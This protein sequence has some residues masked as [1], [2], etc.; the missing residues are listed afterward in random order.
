M[1]HSQQRFKLGLI[2]FSIGTTWAIRICKEKTLSTLS[3]GSRF[4]P[5]A[6]GLHGQA[7]RYLVVPRHSTVGPRAFSVAGPS[8]WNSIRCVLKTHRTEALSV[9]EMFQDVTLYKLTYRYYKRFRTLRHV[10]LPVRGDAIISVQTVNSLQLPTVVSY[11]RRTLP[12]SL[13]HEPTL[14]S[15]IGHSRLLDHGC[16]TA[17]RPT[18][19]SPTLPYISSAAR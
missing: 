2:G 7:P 11:D 17:F 6:P 16:G 9:L 18:Y 13:F 4:T 19:D 8:L 14:V 3:V 5:S 15:V 12:R 10:S 1:N